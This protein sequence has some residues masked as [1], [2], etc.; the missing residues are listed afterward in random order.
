MR[1]G[2][3]V[4]GAGFVLHLAAPG[5]SDVPR[6]GLSVGRGLGRATVRNR[7]RR[8]LREAVRPLLGAMAAVDV[9]I[10]ARPELVDTPTPEL[11]RALETA[12]SS[13]GLL[14][15]RPAPD[16]GWTSGGTMGGQTPPP[17]VPEGTPS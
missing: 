13:A 8:R 14:G 17:D 1:A 12:M 6:V 16:A 11:A 5:R 3:R 10:V 15:A 4:S 7:V 2:R 9:V